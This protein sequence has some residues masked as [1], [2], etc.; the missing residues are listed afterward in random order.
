ML[1]VATGAHRYHTLRI[2]FDAQVYYRVDAERCRICP[3]NGKNMM[4][5]DIMPPDD[6]RW[7]PDERGR[8]GEFGGRFIPE[9]LMAA[10]EELTEA[11]EQ[12]RGDRAFWQ[13]LHDTL[14]SYVGR[15]SPIYFAE[16]LS[17]RLAGGKTP[18]K[19]DLQG[20]TLYP[21]FHRC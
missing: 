15:P 10:V 14:V 20:S 1:L 3:N 17:N 19:R 11:Y 5:I 18:D 2:K 7:G 21:Y 6:R 9:T 12:I 16:R 8:F 13:K 4:Q